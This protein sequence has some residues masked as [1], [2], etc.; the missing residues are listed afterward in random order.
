MKQ[1]K[2]SETELSY[3]GFIR[4]ICTSYST[5]YKNDRCDKLEE[6]ELAVRNV[7]SCKTRTR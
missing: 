7:C 5:K 2:Q 4:V 3:L 1:L 6:D